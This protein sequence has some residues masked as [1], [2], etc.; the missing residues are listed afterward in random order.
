MNSEESFY[1]IAH[2]NHSFQE[3]RG[4]ASLKNTVDVY[5]SI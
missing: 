5:K 3:E 2:R 4:K 1:L